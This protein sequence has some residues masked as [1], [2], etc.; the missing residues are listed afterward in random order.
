MVATWTA[1]FFLPAFA[2]ATREIV[3]RLNQP[4]AV[5]DQDGLVTYANESFR[6]TLGLG[7][8]PLEGR[9][10]F[11]MGNGV[12]DMAATR[13]LL[14]RADHDG[15]VH[16]WRIDADL[17]G[18]GRKVLFVDVVPIRGGSF[19][20]SLT[21]LAVQDE[22]AR[23]LLEEERARL[24][25]AI[26][27][28]PVAVVITDAQGRVIYANPS[29]EAITGRSPSTVAG[30]D[31][32]VSARADRATARRVTADLRRRG[33]WSGIL[34]GRRDDAGTYE[35]DAVVSSVHDQANGV[36]GY[37]GVGRDIATERDLQS[38]LDRERAER[39]E[40][41][42]RLARLQPSA[43]AD[44]A[45]SA[46]CTELLRLPGMVSA[47]VLAFTAA[48]AVV[49]VAVSGPAG[50]PLRR[51][52]ALP[53]VVARGL[54]VRIGNGPWVE[55]ISPATN[56]GLEPY[57]RAWANL[58]V[59]SLAYVPLHGQAEEVVGVLI[60]GSSAVSG[61][62][63]MPRLLATAIEVGAFASAMVGQ[64][65]G[66]LRERARIQ[67]VVWDTVAGNQFQTVFQAMVD[68]STRRVVGYAALTRFNDGTPP[69]QRFAEATSVGLGPILERASLE[70]AI[71]A[72][73]DL[74]PGAWL[75][76][77]V[78]PEYLL[79]HLKPKILLPALGDREVVFEIAD[80]A[81][82]EDYSGVRAAMSRMASERV[83][84]AVDDAG[85]RFAGLNRLLEL[86]PDFIK[87]D[88]SLVRGLEL[89][90]ARRA[91]VVG[92]QHFARETDAQVIAEGVETEEEHR[93]LIGL[94]I[95]LGQGFLYGYPGPLNDHGDEV[96]VI[97]PAPPM[98]L[99]SGSAGPRCH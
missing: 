21:V 35:V 54:R 36:V 33:T 64:S 96:S 52:V 74:P 88:A 81:Q 20:T 82:A 39:A 25:A 50:A 80:G 95:K 66:E 2:R 86:R 4:C 13:E 37:V 42:F 61:G 15:P 19:D 84:I 7:D 65:L 6:A 16:R 32:L 85:A 75:S 98:Q 69:G 10:I 79:K 59:E 68:L 30:T 63:G 49:P 41:A 77:N 73:A 71:A 92:I 72:A 43:P 34:R 99:S 67:Q 91:L 9:P 46:L 58:G 78:S 17:A 18:A 53:E 51:N 90:P 70:A 94:G 29:F 11:E 12:L 38:T 47:A 1:R 44:V 83:K 57:Y 3:A 5:L 26:E 87:L 14:E 27:Q 62:N 8:E 23:V 24:V 93:A 56:D 76:L 40:F 31:L 28:A 45:A 97:P 22:T 55:Q 60:V 48:D 89:D